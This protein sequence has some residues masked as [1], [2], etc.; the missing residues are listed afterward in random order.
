M[1]IHRTASLPPSAEAFNKCNIDSLPSLLSVGDLISSFR[2]VSFSKQSRKMMGYSA[3]SATPLSQESQPFWNAQKGPKAQ[4]THARK[5]NAVSHLTIMVVD[6]CY[7]PT[8]PLASGRAVLS[9]AVI[10]ASGTD[11]TSSS[12]NPT[13]A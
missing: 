13:S 7:L 4:S 2:F 5:T 12:M 8:E 3:L 6:D 9:S 10:S 1:N 11:H